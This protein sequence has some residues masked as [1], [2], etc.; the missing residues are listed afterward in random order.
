MSYDFN[1]LYQEYLSDPLVQ[2]MDY[3]TVDDFI[4]SVYSDLDY[5][6]DNSIDIPDH[7][8]YLIKYIEDQ[9]KVDPHWVKNYAS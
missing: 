6:L 4:D 3:T 7:I 8:S 9:K 1:T 5:H 2:D